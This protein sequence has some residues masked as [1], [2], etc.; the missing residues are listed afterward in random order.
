MDDQFSELRRFDR[1]LHLSHCCVE[2][3]VEPTAEAEQLHHGCTTA[4]RMCLRCVWDSIERLLA[5]EREKVREICAI[6]SCQ[7]CW[8]ARAYPKEH[9]PAYLETKKGPHKG[10]WVHKLIFGK[11]G[12]PGRCRAEAIRQLDLIA[13]SSTEE[14]E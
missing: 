8:N 3:S 5:Q 13:P 9:G 11:Y 14:G 6:E 2:S 4:C 1:G 7:V 12:V 10:H